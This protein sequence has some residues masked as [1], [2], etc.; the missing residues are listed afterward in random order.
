M[1]GLPDINNF[2]DFTQRTSRATAKPVAV[3]PVLSAS[4]LPAVMQAVA[5]YVELLQYEILDQTTVEPPF[6]G[7]AAA[8]D[9]VT[10]SSP[11]TERTTSMRT[12]T[13]TQTTTTTQS[14]IAIVQIRP[15]AAHAPGNYAPILTGLSTE[16][17]NVADGR[18]DEQQIIVTPTTSKATATESTT[19]TNLNRPQL[20]VMQLL[21]ISNQQFFNWFLHSKQQV[22][23]E[24]KQE[25]ES[26]KNLYFYDNIY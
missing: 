25:D 18:E 26:G 9:A 24:A 16:V 15:T 10:E 20:G 5:Y 8:D 17:G 1:P 23:V 14:P 11:T 21:S 13:M 12:T 19:E 3:D 4:Y 6:T 7:N 2:D 22:H